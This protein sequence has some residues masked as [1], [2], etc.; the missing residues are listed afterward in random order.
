MGCLSILSVFRVP[1]TRRP[2]G[3]CWVKPG[4]IVDPDELDQALRQWSSLYAQEDES[5][6]IDGKTMRNAIDHDGKQTHIVS[7][8][9][10]QTHRCH[11]QKKSASY[12]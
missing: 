4:D 3:H 5:F 10:H 6:A 9:S 7:A 2:T 1:F 11:S 8:I 12:G